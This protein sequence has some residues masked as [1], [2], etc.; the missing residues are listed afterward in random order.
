MCLSEEISTMSQTR[1]LFAQKPM[2]QIKPFLNDVSVSLSSKS[3]FSVLWDFR[4]NIWNQTDTSV[5]DN[6]YNPMKEQYICTLGT[7]KWCSSVRL[8][9]EEI[10][11]FKCAL[12]R[13]THTH[14]PLFLKCFSFAS[15]IITDVSCSVCCLLKPH[16]QIPS[17]QICQ[18]CKC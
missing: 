7:V 12:L 17:H 10:C 9:S 5:K 14:T 6:R 1:L 11:K 3:V 15:S 2:F 18:F 13:H 4:R 8:C 16:K